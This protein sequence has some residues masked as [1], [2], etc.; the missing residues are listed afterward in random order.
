MVRVCKKTFLWLKRHKDFRK[1]SCCRNHVDLLRP[2]S[3]TIH[4][5]MLSIKSLGFHSGISGE[6]TTR[7]IKK[8][9]PVWL[10]GLFSSCRTVDYFFIFEC[11]QRQKY[12]TLHILYHKKTFLCVFLPL[13][14]VL[15]LLKTRQKRNITF[16]E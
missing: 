1:I 5:C 9:L 8:P 14:F 10:R 11:L 2:M 12:I 6:K 7:A 3:F 13:N 4:T 16:L 15:S